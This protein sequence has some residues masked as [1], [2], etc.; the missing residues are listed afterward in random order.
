MLKKK[1]FQPQNWKQK[2]DNVSKIIKFKINNFLLI[3][4]FNAR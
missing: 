2:T 4:S 3:Q 1:D